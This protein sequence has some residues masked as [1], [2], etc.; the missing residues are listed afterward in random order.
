M[1]THCP[2]CE[3]DISESYQEAEPDVGIMSGGYYCDACDLPVDE[4]DYEPME[5]DVSIMT[6]TE[7]RGDKPLGTPLSEISGGPGHPGYDEWC[8]IAKSWGYD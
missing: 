1:T 6:A 7:A 3:A 4:E 8:R 5:G 2:K